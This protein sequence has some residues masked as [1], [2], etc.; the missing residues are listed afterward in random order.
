[1]C[2]VIRETLKKYVRLQFPQ[3]VK[4]RT[5]QLGIDRSE[6]GGGAACHFLEGDGRQHRGDLLNCNL[7]NMKK[8]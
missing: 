5:L 7:L 3:S 4:F 8:M 6:K 2:S 1:M